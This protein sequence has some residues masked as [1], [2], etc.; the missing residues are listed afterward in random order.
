MA[1]NSVKIGIIMLIAWV[2][3]LFGFL[4]AGIGL[5]LAIVACA[6]EKNAMARA[7]LFLNALGIGLSALYIAVGIFLLSSGL[8]EPLIPAP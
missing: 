2:I 5:V 4:L 8:L 1:Q 7:G 6:V 3:P